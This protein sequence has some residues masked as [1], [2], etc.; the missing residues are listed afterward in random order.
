M[1]PLSF[2]WSLFG[3]WVSVGLG[4]MMVIEGVDRC[5]EANADAETEGRSEALVAGGAAEFVG[6]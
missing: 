2:R 4:L 1:E 3:I 5:A 6:S